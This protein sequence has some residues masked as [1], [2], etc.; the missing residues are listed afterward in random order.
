MK[1]RHS[2]GVLAP[3]QLG[4][5]V[6]KA[7]LVVRVDLDLRRRD[8]GIVERADRELEAELRLIGERRAA[9]AAEAA[10]RAVRALEPLWLAARPR[11]VARGDQRPEEAAERLLA[12]AAMADRAAAEQPHAE[13][14][15][16]ALA[17]AG[18]SLVMR[19][20]DRPPRYCGRRDRRRRP[21]SSSGDSARGCPAGRC[22]CRR[23]PSPRHRRHRPRRGLGL[24]RDVH[25]PALLA[26]VADP[27]E[28]L[29]R[30]EAGN[31]PVRLVE[32]HQ[33]LDAERRQRLLVE[34]ERGGVVSSAESHVIKAAHRCHLPLGRAFAGVVLAVHQLDALRPTARHGSRRPWRSP[35]R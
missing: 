28:R 2:L 17:A 33:H 16:A 9:L 6:D 15:R 1:S 13:A 14:H 22:P 32:R 20:H 25:P 4:E 12:H 27:E 23:P 3:G 29:L 31:L 24:E 10:A 35:W 26:A 8:L 19:G 5:A 30:P 21:R 18:V 7:H 11:R 34:L